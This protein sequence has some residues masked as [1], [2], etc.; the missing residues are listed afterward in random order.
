MQSEDNVFQKHLLCLFIYY[1]KNIYFNKMILNS[2][3]SD[4]SLNTEYG[5]T[6]ASYY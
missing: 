3:W 2:D 1:I 5:D 4:M 6:L